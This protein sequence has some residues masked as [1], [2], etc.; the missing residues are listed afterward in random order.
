MTSIPETLYSHPIDVVPMYIQVNDR[1][2]HHMDSI[3]PVGAQSQKDKRKH[4]RQSIVNE[5]P[6][7]LKRKLSREEIA[8]MCIHRKQ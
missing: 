6:K 8:L 7:T 2:K 5:K 3:I 1:D 4:K